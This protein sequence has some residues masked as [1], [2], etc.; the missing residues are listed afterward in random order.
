V[1][2]LCEARG[3]VARPE[4][5]SDAS[6]DAQCV[7]RRRTRRWAYVS[8]P[9]SHTHTHTRKRLAPHGRHT[10]L[11]CPASACASARAR[12]GS[13]HSRSAQACSSGTRI[14][15]RCRC[16]R[17][18]GSHWSAAPARIFR[19]ASCG[20]GCRITRALCSKPQRLRS[21]R[22][23]AL[24]RRGQIDGHQCVVGTSY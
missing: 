11:Q 14:V 17:Q 10:S 12:A 20:T 13:A 19:R 18:L 1:D 7:L 3:A 15:F 6:D 23:V 2:R 24:L 9:T 21:V 8:R 5:P 22:F 16:P 4:S